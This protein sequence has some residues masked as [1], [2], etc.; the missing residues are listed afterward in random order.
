MLDSK[1]TTY[2]YGLSDPR[3][4]GV[5]YIGKANNPRLRM[6]GHLRSARKKYTK[7][8]I[9]IR[10]LLE[11]SILPRMEILE[12]VDM[13]EWESKEKGWISHYRATSKDLLN[14]QDGG[15]D[16]ESSAQAKIAN[17]KANAKKVH[18]DPNRRRLWQLK[19]KLGL[20]IK[21]NYVSE[22][23]KIK[24]RKAS[25]AYPEIFGLWSNI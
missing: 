21:D 1:L 2:I 4:G 6:Y 24:I 7:V 9:W 17:G 10:G 12:I 14:M 11:E 5:R 22:S 13:S 8:A 25:I 19:Q 20:L 23:T 3:D 15:Q 18:G 16:P